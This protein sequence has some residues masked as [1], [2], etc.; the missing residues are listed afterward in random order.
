MRRLEAFYGTLTVN[1]ANLIAK[2]STVLSDIDVS[3]K[4]FARNASL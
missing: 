2:R 1:D 3:T 4:F